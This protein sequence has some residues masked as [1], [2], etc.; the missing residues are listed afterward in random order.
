MKQHSLDDLPGAQIEVLLHD[1]EQLLLRLVRGAVVEHRDGQ[2]LRHADR[3][4]HLVHIQIH[5]YTYFY[6]NTSFSPLRDVILSAR[7]FCF[8]PVCI[9]NKCNI[10][11]SRPRG[12]STEAME[13]NVEREV[14]VE[15]MEIIPDIESNLAI[16]KQNEESINKRQWVDSSSEEG[17]NTVSHDRKLRRRVIQTEENK[18]EKIQVCVTCSKQLP[19]QFALAK[20]LKENNINNISRVKYIH[21]YK[22]LITFDSD[23]EANKFI[24]CKTFSDLEWRCQITSEVGISYGIIKDVELDLV[25][26][27]IIKN[28]TSDINIVSAKRLNKRNYKDDTG[29]GWIK[30][31]TIRLGFKGPQLPNHILI[32]NLKVN[33]L[34]YVFPVTQCSRCWKFGHTRLLC[35]STKHVCPKCTKNHENCK[36]T[37]FCCVN[38]RGNHMALQKICPVFQKEK[39]IRELMSEFQCTYR[40]ALTIYVPPSPVSNVRPTEDITSKAKRPSQIYQ[41]AE[42]RTESNGKLLWSELFTTAKDSTPKLTKRNKTRKSH[43]K[44]STSKD[45][46]PTYM[47]TDDHQDESTESDIEV[48][49][50]SDTHNVKQ[51]G[52]SRESRV[53]D[54]SFLQL[55]FKL[56]NIICSEEALEDK[57]QEVLSVCKTWVLSMIVSGITD[58]SFLNLFRDRA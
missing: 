34:P 58:G 33:V 21:N 12:R 16:N 56:K 31:E 38:C 42:G 39:R 40:K 2:R 28:I 4:R 36:T 46:A 20:I 8:T 13:I 55:L 37:N 41:I 3:V 19:K 15:D 49:V 32:H 57:I 54:L 22:I 10:I 44:P 14:D 11:S 45:P 30:C 48:R 5:R 23:L 29:S 27:E 35:P 18:Q 50:T 17:W 52:S 1:G 43:H 53:Q 7:V 6:T 24:E 26:D 9:V 51:H 25:D 47:E